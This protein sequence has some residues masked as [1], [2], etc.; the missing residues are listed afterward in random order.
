MRRYLPLVFGV[1]AGLV[2]VR[3]GVWQLNRLSER[4]A[5]NVRRESRLAMAVVNL[6][7]HPT[8]DSL[9]GR[10]ASATGV[11]DFERQIVVMLRGLRGVPG[12]HIVT[13]LRLEDG[14]AVL[15]ERGWAPSSD[16]KT[17][18]LSKLAEPDTSVVEGL[19][20]LSSGQAEMSIADNW[21]IYVRRPNPVDLESRF[22]YSLMPEVLRRT[23][24]PAAAPPVLRP[25][26]LPDLT[27]G[28]HLSYA[29]QWFSFAVIA[30]VG[31][32]ILVWRESRPGSGVNERHTDS[33]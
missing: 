23:E 2:C 12:V 31:S 33:L 7:E 24:L 10:R 30:V 1:V 25:L 26:P 20:V 13:P 29:I 28:P 3:L 8:E 22:P 15:V 9:E 14:T 6:D 11:F 16:G 4:R 32:A 19:L 5:V 27:N 21:P 18:E 17:V